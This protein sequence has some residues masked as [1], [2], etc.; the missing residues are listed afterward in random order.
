[1]V[2]LKYFY[3]VFLFLFFLNL[4]FYFNVFSF[5]VNFVDYVDEETVIFLAVFIVSFLFVFLNSKE[6]ST[7]IDLR[8]E[9]IENNFKKNYKITIE[10]LILLEN[11]FLRLELLL[12]SVAN[13]NNSFFFELIYFRFNKFENKLLDLLFLSILLDFLKND[14]LNFFLLKKR[15]QNFLI[16]KTVSK[17]FLKS[18]HKINLTT[19]LFLK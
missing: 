18:F 4:F 11:I 17:W 15:Y 14:F 6:L 7:S 13:N 12:S 10:N 19:I 16:S 9:N 5:Y 3:Q 1:M 2:F 8:I